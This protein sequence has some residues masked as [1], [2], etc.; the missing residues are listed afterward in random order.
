MNLT[1]GWKTS[2]VPAHGFAVTG[3]A[4]FD[5]GRRLSNR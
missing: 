2:E 4:S 5:A 3:T 1:T